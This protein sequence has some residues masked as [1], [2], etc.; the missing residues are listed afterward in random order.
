MRVVDAQT[1]TAGGYIQHTWDLTDRVILETGLR[2][3][4]MNFK[5]AGYAKNQTFVS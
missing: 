3:D 4:N 1:F 2:V 5:N